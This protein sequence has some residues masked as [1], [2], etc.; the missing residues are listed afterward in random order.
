MAEAAN[1]QTDNDQLR[2]VRPSFWR[3]GVDNFTDPPAQNPDSFAVLHNVMC[4]VR[5]RITR[6]WGT[7]LFASNAVPVNAERIHEVHFVNGR[8]RFVETATDGTGVDSPSNTVEVVNEKGDLAT[9]AAPVFTPSENAG[10]V[11]CAASRDYA[12]FADGIAADLLKWDTADDTTGGIV[13]PDTGATIPSVTKN[14]IAAPVPAGVGG[15]IDGAATAEGTGNI[16]LVSGRAYTV[17]YR[18]S[19]SGHVSSIAPFSGSL[20]VTSDPTDPVATGVQINLSAIPLSDDPQ[21]DQRVILATADGGDQDTLYE[22]TILND[23][24]TDTYID[25]KSEFDLLNSQIW[26]E[27]GS[28]GIAHGCI[29]N[30]AVWE[31]FPET[32]ICCAHR[33]RMYYLQG[34]FLAWSKTLYE[35]TT[36]TGNIAGRW[37]EAVP[38]ENQTSLSSNGSEVGTSLRSDDINLYIGTNRTVY[39]LRGDNPGLFP[40]SAISQEVGVINNAVWRTIY[41]EGDAIGA[42]WLTPEYRVIRAN[43]NTY[44]DAGNPIQTTLSAFGDVADTATATFV[45]HGPFEFYILA[46]G[47]DASDPSTIWVYNVKTRVWFDWQ[48]AYGEDVLAV[49]YMFDSINRRPLPIYSTTEQRLY[50]WDNAL[51]TDHTSEAPLLPNCS[52]IETVWLGG[53]DPSLTK[54]LNAIEVQSAEPSITVS[55]YGANSEADFVSKTLIGTLD[56]VTNDFGN[57][58]APCA[59][60][61]TAHKFYKFA[62]GGLDDSPEID[63]LSYQSIEHVPFA[64][65]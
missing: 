8:N 42:M 5:A 46:P 60:L 50:R 17:A 26:A 61:R 33:G 62:Y 6:R 15:A 52:P 35:L 10:P 25:N 38:I 49:G 64:H 7:T 37:E 19:V 39:V 14:G 63:L 32:T 30:G 44:E 56:F 43:F 13:S 28:D 1:I 21:V 16:A 41:H 54:I 29:G 3:A 57:L 53:E 48:S 65:L 36:S 12:F 51:T 31:N 34:H 58:W 27:V 55:I 22:V 18:C 23:N 4:G 2:Y 59:H 45:G 47:S 24:T 20:G 9:T 11:E 40:P